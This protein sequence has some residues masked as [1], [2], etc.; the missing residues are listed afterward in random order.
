MKN[1]DLLE[2]L[3]QRWVI[4]V[5]LLYSAVTWVAVQA[6]DLLV[7]ADILS[8]R[9]V[10]ALLLAAVAGLPAT[11]IA[12]WFLDSKR[13]EED[14]TTAPADIAVIVAVTLIAALFIRQQWFVSF[15]R[16]SITIEGIEST[17][18]RRDTARRAERIAENL[19][20]I[21]AMRTEMRVLEYGEIDP[22][23]D[24]HVSGTMARGAG[25]VRLSVQLHDG[26]GRLV[27]GET[28]TDNARN[29]NQLLNRVQQGLYS[30]LPLPPRAYEEAYDLVADCPS[31]IERGNYIDLARTNF[32]DLDDLPSNRQPVAQKLAMQH[33]ANADELCPGWQDTKLLRLKNTLEVDRGQI[34]DA[35]LLKDYPN[36]AFVHRK[37]GERLSEEGNPDEASALFEEA[38]R[39]QPSLAL[40]ECAAH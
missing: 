23:A 38:C 10:Q 8:D 2:T 17:D 40:P 33:L 31:L 6:A 1:N 7:S 24:F 27:W 28:F 30:N 19:R 5:A 9:F 39:L 14:A 21:L 13:R 37:I 12:G 32:D 34:S 22:D 25:T 20:S 18:T 35:K 16:P 15:E 3:K 11:L 36:S 26:R 29:E 4:R